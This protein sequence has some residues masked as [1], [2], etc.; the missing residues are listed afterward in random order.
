V[1]GLSLAELFLILLFLLLLAFIGI[2]TTH[3]QKISVLEKEISD[4]SDL[5]DGLRVL[6]EKIGYPITDVA[7]KDLVA[8]QGENQKLKEENSELLDMLSQDKDTIDQLSSKLTD[9]EDSLA[10]AKENVEEAVERAQSTARALDA[11]KRKPGDIPPCWFVEVPSEKGFR[12][13]HLKIYNVKI[14]DQSFMIRKH[15][16]DYPENANFGN[17]NSLP[18]IDTKYFET[19]LNAIEFKR[20]F[21]SIREAGRNRQ[22]QD[23]SCRFMVDVYDATSTENKVGFKSQLRA[24]EDVFYKFEETRLW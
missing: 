13:R 22:I 9:T 14:T 16:Y 5:R 19:E 11:I 4:D 12:Q 21:K 3:K 8:S 15:K 7:L 17:K 24:V 18:K 10:E 20:A 23:Y 1:L 6:K 2:T